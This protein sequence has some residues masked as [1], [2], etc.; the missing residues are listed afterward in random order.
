MAKHT[1]LK[2][3]HSMNNVGRQA[4]RYANGAA[5]CTLLFCVTG[6]V[7][8]LLFEEEIQEYGGLSRNMATAFITGAIYKSTL[9]LRPMVLGSVLGVG[10]V[11]GLTKGFNFLNDHGIIGFRVDI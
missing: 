9:G 7:I 11:Y 6:K 2:A 5:C 10:T 1:Q 8:D 4:S 3:Y